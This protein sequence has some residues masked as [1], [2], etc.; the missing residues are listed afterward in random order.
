MFCQYFQNPSDCSFVFFFH[1]CKDQNVVQVHYYDSLSYEG[2]EDVVHHSLE[3]GRTIGYSK[4][5]H[6]RFAETAIGIEGH[7][8]FISGLDAHVIETPADI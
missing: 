7:L 1:L 3:G 6:E 5:H 4:E 8:P 2:S